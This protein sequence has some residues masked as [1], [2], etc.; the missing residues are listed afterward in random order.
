MAPSLNTAEDLGI[1]LHPYFKLYIDGIEA[2][3][4]LTHFR[5]IQS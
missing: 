2:E 5:D 4:H 1:T 3:D